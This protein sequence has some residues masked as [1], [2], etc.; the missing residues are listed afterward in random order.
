MQ[1]KQCCQRLHPQSWYQL[2]LL[3]LLLLLVC[4]YLRQLPTRLGLK[5]HALVLVL[6]LAPVLVHER[7]SL[8]QLTQVSCCSQ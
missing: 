5:L 4:H 8:D 2:H 1:L 7:A 6:V 3:L